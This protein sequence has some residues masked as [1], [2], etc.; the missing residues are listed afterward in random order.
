ML[1][2][3]H[4]EEQKPR[5]N[6]ALCL[7]WGFMEKEESAVYQRILKRA[8]KSYSLERRFLKKSTSPSYKKGYVISEKN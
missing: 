1:F 6:Y 7:L 2:Q 4:G 3:Y 8:K 5:G